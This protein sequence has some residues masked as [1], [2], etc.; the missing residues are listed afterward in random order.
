MIANVKI[1][2]V[3][4]HVE[5]AS[6]DADFFDA[7]PASENAYSSNL[8]MI[9]KVKILLVHFYVERASLDADPLIPDRH[10]RMP[11]PRIYYKQSNPIP[12]APTPHDLLRPRSK[13]TRKPATTPTPTK[14]VHLRAAA[15]TGAISLPQARRNPLR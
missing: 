7:G 6:S 14:I 10:L 4:F 9:G 11:T 8:L 5:K 15:S 12:Q 1:L 13:P 3:Y 2:L